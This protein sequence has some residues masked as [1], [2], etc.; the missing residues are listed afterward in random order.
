MVESA[1]F[2]GANVRLTIRLGSGRLII[3][4]RPSF[5]ASGQWPRSIAVSLKPDPLRAAIITD[6]H[7]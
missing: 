3:A 6:E 1:T 7:P 2:L 4:D 5:E